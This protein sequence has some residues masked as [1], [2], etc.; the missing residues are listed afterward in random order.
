MHACDSLCTDEWEEM[1]IVAVSDAVSTVFQQQEFQELLTA[2]HMQ[3]PSDTVSHIVFLAYTS[4][5]VDL[6]RVY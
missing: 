3:P 5:S 2:L 4:I 1:C 6:S